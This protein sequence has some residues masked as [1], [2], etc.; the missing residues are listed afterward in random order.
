MSPDVTRIDL[1]C[2]HAFTA[3]LDCR[4]IKISK[5]LSLA[6]KLERSAR[7]VAENRLRDIRAARAG[8]R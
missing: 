4:V 8:A 7:I 6:N 5:P 1:F 3:D 2:T